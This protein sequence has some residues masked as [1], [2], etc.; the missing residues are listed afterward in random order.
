MPK[1]IIVLTCLVLVLLGGGIAAADI[2]TGLIAYY[3]FAGNPNDVV[4]GNNGTVYG[5]T[6]LIAGRFGR[7]NNAYHFDGG[8]SH[9]ELDHNFD[10]IGMGTNVTISAWVKTD[11]GGF[12]FHQGNYGELLLYIGY[13]HAE[14][15]VKL[16][17][18]NF[19][20]A[21]DTDSFPAGRWVNV[22]GV[23]YRYNKIEL[24]LD[25]KLITTTFLPNYDLF[26][27][28]W[29]WWYANIGAYHQEGQDLRIPFWGSI[30]EVRIYNRA[31]TEADIKQL[32]AFGT[33]ITGAVWLLLEE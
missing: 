25:G 13:G 21:L 14:F 10:F 7:P 22:T 5:D 11:A 18:E 4:G 29:S 30:T 2:T 23:Y 15:A 17:D 27:P 8:T 32:V 16:A 6:P 33:P 20:N 3:P 28:A 19:Y 24:W 26:N 31:L 1:T 9:I 12:I